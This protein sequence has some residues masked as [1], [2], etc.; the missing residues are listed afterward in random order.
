MTD[1][2]L[3]GVQFSATS[4]WSDWDS[5]VVTVIGRIESHEAAD[6]LARHLQR[7]LTFGARYLLLDFSAVGSCNQ[8][9]LKVLLAAR[10]EAR[11][12]Q[13]WLCVLG[14][15]LLLDQLTGFSPQPADGRHT[16]IAY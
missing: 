7:L 11:L 16:Q 14:P 6:E 3:V 12:W 15:T 13:G 5:P 2:S 8:L 4:V 1:V 10:E 9:G